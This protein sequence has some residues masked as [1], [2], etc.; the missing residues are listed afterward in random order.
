MTQELKGVV[1]FGYGP[2]PMDFISKASK[3][4]GDGA[5]IDQVAARMA[6]ATFAF[7]QPEL[8]A[9]LRQR[10]ETGA[11]IAQKVET[12]GLPMAATTWLACGER[13]ISSNTMFTVLTGVD[14][15]GDT[16]QSHPHDPA[17]LDRCLR[18]LDQVPALRLLLP[19][20]AGVSPEWAALIAHWEEIERLHL[21]EVGLGWTKAKSAPRTYELMRKVIDSA[22]ETV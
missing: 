1:V 8:F 22:K 9:E 13:G 20:M 5:V 7:G 16:R 18:L 19:K 21:D 6:G 10:L 11:L 4:I 14:A 2:K 15:L 17:D 3:M 12:P